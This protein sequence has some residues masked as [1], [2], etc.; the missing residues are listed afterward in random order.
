MHMIIGGQIL[1]CWNTL[2][3]TFQGIEGVAGFRLIAFD[4]HDVGRGNECPVWEHRMPIDEPRH[5]RPVRA[6][7]HEP[8]FNLALVWF[9]FIHAAVPFIWR[10]R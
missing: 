10:E 9:T 1:P 3:V 2:F 6:W 7:V 5:C 8:L 4:V